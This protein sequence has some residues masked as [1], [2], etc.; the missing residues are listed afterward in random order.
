MT[1]GFAVIFEEI[2]VLFAGDLSELLLLQKMR[3]KESEQ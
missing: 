1:S 3:G 2:N